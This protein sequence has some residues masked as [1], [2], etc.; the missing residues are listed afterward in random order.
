MSRS[1]KKTPIG[2][3]T[4]AESE[5]WEKKKWHRKLRKQT[6]QVL[7]STHYDQEL[8]EETILP[9]VHDVSDPWTMRKDGK[10]YLSNIKNWFIEKMLRK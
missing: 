10:I 2:G 5:K 8:L 9:D 6:K 1:V 7:A 3:I 4:S